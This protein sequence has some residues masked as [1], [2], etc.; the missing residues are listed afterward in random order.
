MRQGYTKLKNMSEAEL[1]AHKKALQDKANLRYKMRQQGLYVEPYKSKI[2][3]GKT[4]YEREMLAKCDELYSMDL[5]IKAFY[6][7]LKKHRED[8]LPTLEKIKRGEN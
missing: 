5:F 4:P 1:K 6:L 2:L 7:A 8:F 3:E